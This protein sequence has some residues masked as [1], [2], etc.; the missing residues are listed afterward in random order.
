M[1]IAGDSFA[2]RLDVKRLGKNKEDV[3]TVAKGGSKIH[4]VQKS[5][6]DFAASNPSLYVKKL[7]LSIGTNDIRHCNKGVQHLKNPVGD[8]MKC[9]KKLFPG[10]KVYFQSIPPIHPNGSQ[11]TVGN[12][13]SMNNLIF[14][15][16]SRYRLFY[17]NIFNAFLNEYGDRNDR[18][19]PEFDYVKDTFDIHPSPK[20]GM[21]VLAK[22][23]IRIIHSKWF[24]PMG[25]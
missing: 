21:P 1:L 2:A 7:F 13:L 3:R 17:L 6:E 16:C 23:Y 15:L 8:L 11:Y 9:V 20:K 5:L 18:L 22:F 19:F 14:N 4:E 25:Y 12:V 24:N 10:A